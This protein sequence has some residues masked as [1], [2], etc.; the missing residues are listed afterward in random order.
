[1][2]ELVAEAGSRELKVSYQLFQQLFRSSSVKVVHL[3]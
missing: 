1:M 3:E 2:A